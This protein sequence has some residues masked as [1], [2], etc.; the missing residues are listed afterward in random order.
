MDVTPV[1]GTLE[2]LAREHAALR[3]MATLVASEPPPDEVFSAVTREAGLLLGAQRGTLLRVVSAQWAEKYARADRVSVDVAATDGALE[4]T[5]AD[6]G[7]GGAD[8]A[9]GSGLRGLVDR[10]TAVGGRLDVSSPPGQGTRLCARLPASIL[11]T[12]PASR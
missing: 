6:D 9:K 5:I 2:Q 10:V 8:P 4:V 11:G 1:G 12:L 3:R 7:A